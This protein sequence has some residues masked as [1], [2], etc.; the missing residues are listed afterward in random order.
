MIEV[1]RCAEIPLKR[2]MASLLNQQKW[3][4]GESVLDTIIGGSSL[5]DSA[6]G[7]R[8]SFTDAESIENYINAYGYDLHDPIEAAELQGNVQEAIRFIKK[9]FIKIKAFSVCQ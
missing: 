4:I 6:Q 5:L 7:L 3:K 2:V 1:S 8:G 9:Y